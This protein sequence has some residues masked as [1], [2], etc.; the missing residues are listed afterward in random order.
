[1]IVLEVDID[2]PAIAP[3]ERDPPVLVDGERKAPRHSAQTMK[4]QSRDICVLGGSSLV[5]D[6]QKVQDPLDK[7]GTKAPAIILFPKLTQRLAAE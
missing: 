4:P 7:V 3:A 1:M 2:R 6:V 5:E